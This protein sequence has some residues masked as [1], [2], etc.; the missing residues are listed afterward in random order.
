[1]K[2]KHKVRLVCWL[3]FTTAVIGLGCFRAWSL[4]DVIALGV[5]VA[6]GV[7]LGFVVFGDSWLMRR[8]ARMS[9]Q[10][11]EKFIAQFSTEEQQR[12]LAKL[13]DY[14]DRHKNA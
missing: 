1:M 3:I 4:F 5:A 2:A 12:L 6:Y 8:I 13:R 10:E 14:L 7:F 11:R 9:A